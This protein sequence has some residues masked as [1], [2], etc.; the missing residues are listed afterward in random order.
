M[1]LLLIP[2]LATLA[3][4]AIVFVLFNLFQ[5]SWLVRLAAPWIERSTGLL[6]RV[7]VRD[8]DV[9]YVAL[10]FDDGPDDVV[11]PRVLNSLR[12]AGVHATWFLVGESVARYPAI[13]REIQSHG[14]ELA[15]HFWTRKAALFIT[16][17]ALL[18]SAIRTRNTLVEIIAAGTLSPPSSLI[19]PA[20]GWARP[21]VV[22]RLAG[23]GFRTVVASVYAGDGMAIPS[24]YVRWATVRM[25]TPGD[26]IVLHVGRGRER[27]A[28]AVPDIVRGLRGKG[29][30]PITLGSL[31]G[32]TSDGIPNRPSMETHLDARVSI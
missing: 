7:D 23:V 1:V 25:A 3:I 9:P 16:D 2:I 12:E 21:S 32:L 29:L 22:R 31:L 18:D 11:T 17:E 13:T 20:S 30:E 8:A 24:W 28:D 4:C 19:R 14:H 10:T 15:N 6:L 26:V 27:T 5:P